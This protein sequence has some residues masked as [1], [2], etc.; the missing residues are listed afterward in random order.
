M[1]VREVSSRC[2]SSRRQP[3]EARDLECPCI[4][5]ALVGRVRFFHD[6]M[7]FI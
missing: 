3:L 5:L 1:R 4:A 2:R 6:T 7:H